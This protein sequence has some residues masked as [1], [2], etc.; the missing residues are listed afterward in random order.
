MSLHPFPKLP[1]HYTPTVTIT[2]ELTFTQLCYRNQPDFLSIAA[3]CQREGLSPYWPMTLSLSLALRR[4]AN[5]GEQREPS[6]HSPD[7]N[8][9][10]PVL[11]LVIML[12]TVTLRLRC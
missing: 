4:N 9:F 6:G 8:S 12:F 10:V 1:R 5:S 7:Y 2:T 11:T 3:W